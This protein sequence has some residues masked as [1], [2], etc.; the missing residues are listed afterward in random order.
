ME[1]IMN[2]GVG[3]KLVYWGTGKIA[4][5]CLE[6]FPDVRP[7]FFIDSYWNTTEKFHE[8]SVSRP[9]E[10]KNWDEL[11]IVIVTESRCYEEIEVILKEK[12]LE[13]ER[14]YISCKDFFGYHRKTVIEMITFFEEFIRENSCYK[15]ATLIFG[16]LFTTRRPETMI[17]FFRAYGQKKAPGKC[18]FFTSLGTVNEE[19]AEKKI[20]FPVFD[21]PQI[22]SWSERENESILEQDDKFGL[23][24]ELTFEETKWLEYLEQRKIS[25]D[26]E[27]SF[28]MTA[29]IYLYYKKLFE[30][31]QPKEVIIW[32]GWAR[33]SY[34]LAE[35][36]KRNN[37]SVRFMEHGWI[38]GTY[39]L[40]RGGI[41]GES[42]YAICPDK[43][44]GL[45][46]KNK[47]MDVRAIREYI[48]KV[49]LDNGKFYSND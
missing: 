20:G 22:C 19:Y 1:E 14:D 42:E 30:I 23:V 26:K 7:L 45:T 41:G 43:I 18:V 9:N 3:K 44:L 21:N 40:E 29:K 46:V 15:N 48:K 47:A 25:V 17:N 37:I 12:G 39:Q 28:I 11:F 4:N 13:K 5:V 49:Q 33:V 27:R 38:P 8:T 36:S 35:L 24:N 32:G 6:Q 10:I 2:L 16:S 34:I 31:F